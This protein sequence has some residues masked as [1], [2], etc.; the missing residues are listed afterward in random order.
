MINDRQRW[1]TQLLIVV[2]AGLLLW[3]AAQLLMAA[4]DRRQ[5]DVTL[6]DRRAEGMP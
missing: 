6:E 3:V 5:Y 2:G 4:S 1:A